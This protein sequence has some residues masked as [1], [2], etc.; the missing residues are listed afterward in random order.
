LRSPP[1]PRIPSLSSDRL[2]SEVSVDRI[3]ILR[4][5]RRTIPRPHVYHEGELADKARG[6]HRF[7][8]PVGV[9]PSVSES[10]RYRSRYRNRLWSF[11]CRSA[12][13]RTGNTENLAPFLP[14]QKLVEL[15]ALKPRGER[16]PVPVFF[17]HQGISAHNRVK[18]ALQP[19]IAKRP[20]RYPAPSGIFPPRSRLYSPEQKYSSW[21]SRSNSCH[22]RN[23]RHP[24]PLSA[25]GSPVCGMSWATILPNV[26]R[27]LPHVQNQVHHPPAQRPDQ[28]P[29]MRIPLEMQTPD[30]LR[31]RIAF[32]ALQE[33][34]PR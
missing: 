14:P 18:P 13:F 1:N 28:F 27:S 33:P 12:Q 16:M 11:R 5:G 9:D 19:R 2:I 26:R 20:V 30:R 23:R 24:D 29:H 25:V 6:I 17:R 3:K 32:I 4:A 21:D 15:P 22:E 31:P 8:F 10:H 34:D 7:P